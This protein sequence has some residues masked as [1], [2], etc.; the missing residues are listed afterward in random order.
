[1]WTQSIWRIALSTGLAVAGG[2][3]LVG[4]LASLPGQ[5]PAPSEPE[6]VLS[7]PGASRD[8]AG[9]QDGAAAATRQTPELAH[10]IDR[11]EAMLADAPPAGPTAG[12]TETAQAEGPWSGT[13]APDELGSIAPA[14]GRPTPGASDADVTA[15]SAAEQP[16]EASRESATPQTAGR[17]PLGADAGAASDTSHF[18]LGSDRGA[19]AGPYIAS[20]M[21]E[22]ALLADAAATEPEPDAN[23]A[24]AKPSAARQA[25]APALGSEP[26]ADPEVI[27]FVIIGSFRHDELA[28]R[29]A[30]NH[31]DWLP[32]ILTKNLGGTTQYRVAIGPFR[33]ADL[34]AARQRVIASGIA[35]AWLLP[36]GKAAIATPLQT[37]DILG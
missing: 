3:S 37:L 17:V 36:L 5:V 34:S 29:H 35:D 6:S 33:A 20:T 25:A 4:V 14:A 26:A 18:D 27:G 9:L 13:P 24:A 10:A 32:Q 8:N 22:A 16:V 15:S 12:R 2:L 1:M 23:E 11:I 28:A 31:R 19:V 21:R 7:G 30:A